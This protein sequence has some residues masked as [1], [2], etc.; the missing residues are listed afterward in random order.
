MSGMKTASKQ[1]PD[2]PRELKNLLLL[3]RELSAQ[4][5]AQIDHLSQQYQHILEQFRLAQQR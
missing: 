2:D 5:D 3:E 1:L 4:K